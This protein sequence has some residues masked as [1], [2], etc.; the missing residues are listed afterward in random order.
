[1]LWDVPRATSCAIPLPHCRG[2][3]AGAPCMLGG[4]HSIALHPHRSHFATS[5]RSSADMAIFNAHTLEPTAIL[6]GHADWIFGMT[7]LDAEHLLTASRDTTV[8]LWRPMRPQDG[9]S[10]SLPSACV[11]VGIAHADKVRALAVD[12]I[13]QQ[14][15]TASLDGHLQL[16]DSQKFEPSTK[17]LLQGTKDLVC[18]SL[19]ET[20]GAFSIGSNKHIA[21]VDFRM[22]NVAME[23]P[24]VDEG[25]GVR[26]ISTRNQVLTVGGGLG[27]LAFYDLRASKYLHCRPNTAAGSNH[28]LC[29]GEGWLKRDTIYEE[30]FQHHVMQQAVYTH[31]YHPSGSKV[32]VGGGP[33]YFGLAG[34]YAAVW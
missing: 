26:T 13:R 29:V 12:S 28:F 21:L 1:M 19:D 4:I 24:S 30:F 14:M 23:I 32:F 5:G 20:S 22:G 2:A 31:A 16:W 25:G 8:R 33:R 18:A 11:A 9:S 7:W 27:R 34:S 10:H 17:V 6:Q 15:V 3:A